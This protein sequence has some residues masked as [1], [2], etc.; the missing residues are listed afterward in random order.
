MSTKPC[1][2]NIQL[3]SN[4]TYE[5]VYNNETVPIQRL[6]IKFV[7]KNTLSQRIRVA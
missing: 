2:L 3:V 5:I 6:A 4:K 1:K 7:S